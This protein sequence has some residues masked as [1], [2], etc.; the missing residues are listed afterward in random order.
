MVTKDSRMEYGPHDDNDAMEIMDHFGLG[1]VDD[2]SCRIVK[3]V[4]WW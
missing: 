4:I 1:S 3:E 2:Q